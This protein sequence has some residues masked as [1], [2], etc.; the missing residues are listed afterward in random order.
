MT[1]AELDHQLKQIQRMVD[2]YTRSDNKKYRVV[3]EDK[4]PEDGSSQA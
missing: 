3:L 1:D 2:Y 4:E